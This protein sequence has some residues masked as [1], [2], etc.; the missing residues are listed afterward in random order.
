MD[1]QSTLYRSTLL[2]VLSAAVLA[3][4]G[5][6]GGFG[7]PDTYV[8]ESPLDQLGAPRFSSEEGGVCRSSLDCSGG[9]RCLS[10]QGFQFCVQTCTTPQE[11]TTN[12]CN[13]VVGDDGWCS[14]PDRLLGSP[15]A[16]PANDDDTPV[17]SPPEPEPDPI[18]EPEP[19]QPDPQPEPEPQQP[20]PS[21]SC[22]S[23]LE[24]EQ[25][26]LLNADRRAQGLRELACHSGLG[27]VAREHSQDMAVRGYFDHV[28]PEGEQP[29][30]RM[31][32]NGVTGWRSVGENIAAGYPT[33]QEV[34]EGWMN[35]PGHRANILNS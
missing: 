13:P 8:D 33:P 3:W 26:Q 35:S 28:N 6:V 4:T 23:A 20:E 32:R 30:D 1:F 15:S 11:C 25:W 5:C 24:S 7:G 34:Q 22:G 21:G 10:S 29:W 9:L 17:G 18:S 12:T 31:E 2:C 19:Q 14:L 27:Q 16:S